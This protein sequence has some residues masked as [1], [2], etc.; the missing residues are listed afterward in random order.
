MSTNYNHSRSK[1]I[2]N[3]RHELINF[4]VTDKRLKEDMTSEQRYIFEHKIDFIPN[5]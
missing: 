3:Q 5:H 4:D 2:I 1:R